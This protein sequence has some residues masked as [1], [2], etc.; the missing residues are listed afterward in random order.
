MNSSRIARGVLLGVIPAIA[1]LVAARQIY[2]QRTEDLSTWKG[3]GMGMFAS[4]DSMLTRYAK[5]Y[6]LLPDGRRQPLLRITPHQEYLRQ[7]A[8]WFPTEDNFRLLA[9]SIKATTWWASTDQVP[10]NVFDENGQRA[11]DG[12]ERYHDLY[13]TSA[14]KPTEP[15]KWGVEIEYWKAAYDLDTGQLTAKLTRTFIYKDRP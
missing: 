5:V 12:V 3:G 9:N 1:I 8:L 13:P 15:P 4:A 14:R 7:Q 6:L 11:S 2:L 10:L